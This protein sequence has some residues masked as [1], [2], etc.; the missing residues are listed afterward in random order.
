MVE[1]GGQGTHR[2]IAFQPLNLALPSA[3]LSFLPDGVIPLTSEAW[4]H[5]AMI[6]S[7]K[8]FIIQKKGG[9]RLCSFLYESCLVLCFV[10]F[11]RLSP[12]S[13]LIVFQVC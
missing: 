7:A 11:S 4:R 12:H 8:Y 10:L 5:I 3:I 6:A 9:K 13:L 1:P 2:D